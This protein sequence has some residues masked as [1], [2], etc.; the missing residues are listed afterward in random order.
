[1]GLTC[2]VLKLKEN[3]LWALISEVCSPSE[4]SKDTPE[5]GLSMWNERCSSARDQSLHS[6]R[7]S[8]SNSMG[9]PP[10]QTTDTD[11][12]APACEQEHPSE[13]RF[14]QMLDDELSSQLP[15]SKPVNLTEQGD[16][17]SAGQT[18]VT[19]P[20]QAVQG[21]SLVTDEG[22]TGHSPR[23]ASPPT[24]LPRALREIVALSSLPS[25][26]LPLL[27][28]GFSRRHVVQAMMATRTRETADAH[29]INMLV[30][31]LLEHPFS[32]DRV[33]HLNFVITKH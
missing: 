1:M 2:F 25:Y 19:G 28:M 33:G 20:S 4:D 21:S 13:R 18:S 10:T 22:S 23:P 8:S 12:I 16:C 27:E 29:R 26:A 5:E 32:D 31:W 24:S 17:M 6:S 14:S 15:S 11:D 9:S 3:V 7:S 30:T